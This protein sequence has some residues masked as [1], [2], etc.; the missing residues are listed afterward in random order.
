M[1]A[2]DFH[3]G[4][5]NRVAQAL[6]VPLASEAFGRASADQRPNLLLSPT[7]AYKIWGNIGFDQSLRPPF[8]KAAVSN[9]QRIRLL[10]A[11]PAT[12]DCEQETEYLPTRHAPNTWFCCHCGN[13]HSLATPR[14]V[15][16]EHDRCNICNVE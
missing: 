1:A 7:S 6:A 12:N 14:C 16:C 11:N 10:L 15:I 8:E 4:H 3:L 9:T 2:L 5:D 13:S